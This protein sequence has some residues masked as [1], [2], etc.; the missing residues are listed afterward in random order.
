LDSE[1]EQYLPDKEEYLKI[2]N[3]LDILKENQSGK[4]KWQEGLN[5]LGYTITK[6][7]LLKVL[8]LENTDLYIK[9][10]AKTRKYLVEFINN[11]NRSPIYSNIN[12]NETIKASQILFEVEANLLKGESVLVE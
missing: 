7:V 9:G 8:L 4:I 3:K 5:E 12:L 1:L 6:G 11:L 10:S 2:K